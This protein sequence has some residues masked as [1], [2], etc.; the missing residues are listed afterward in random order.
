MDRFCSHFIHRGSYILTF[1]FDILMELQQLLRPQ[2]RRHSLIRRSPHRAQM[3]HLPPL[4]RT[5]LLI[6]MQPHPRHRQR[7]IKVRLPRRAIL[8]QPHIAQQIRNR[9]RLHDLTSP[10]GRSH[11]ARTSCSNWLVTRSA[12]ARVIAVVRPRS[13]LVHQQLS[14]GR[15]EHL[16]RQNPLQLKRV[17]QSPPQSRAPQPPSHRVSGA[18]ITLHARIWF[19]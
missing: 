1:L 17:A 11:T 7:R 3:P 8:V 2:H 18:G 13:K 4:A 6:Q 19:S 5:M 14:V 10:S 9:A 12:L 16:H 15:A